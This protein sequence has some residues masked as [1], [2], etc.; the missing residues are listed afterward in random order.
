[1]NSRLGRWSARL[2]RAALA[3][4]RSWVE[5]GAA[6]QAAALV[7]VSTQPASE[8]GAAEAPPAASVAWS[9]ADEGPPED[10][11]RYVTARSQALDGSRVYAPRTA[12][13]R[14]A[15]E[16]LAPPSFRR[17]A[18]HLAAWARARLPLPEMRPAE[19]SEP[20]RAT[21]ARAGGNDR[22]GPGTSQGVAPGAG[23]G[24]MPNATGPRPGRSVAAAELAP[25]PASTGRPGGV[26]AR[27]ASP[28]AEVRPARARPSARPLEPASP[29]PPRSV[30]TSESEPP[31]AEV[32]LRDPRVPPRMPLPRELEPAAPAAPPLAPPARSA[33]PASTL[34]AHAPAR[35]GARPGDVA[36]LE[37][38]P[39]RAREPAP[40]PRAHA[41]A[42]RVEH[43]EL[44]PRLRLRASPELARAEPPRHTGEPPAAPPPRE[45][46]AA[47]RA[48][49]PARGDVRAEL[50][51]SAAAFTASGAASASSPAAVPHGAASSSRAAAP[52]PAGT[53]P[54]HFA[55]P[56]TDRSHLKTDRSR[57][58]N[59]PARTAPAL[60]LAPRAPQ[61]GEAPPPARFAELPRR[62]VAPLAHPAVDAWPELPPSPA[63]PIGAHS[64]ERQNQL[65]REQSEV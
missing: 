57:N 46:R 7:A 59:E 47:R 35:R 12:T 51:P 20:A 2:E 37:G 10:W 28:S 60:G 27:D 63:D 8:E 14:A 32:Q 45:A 4:A 58:G 31:R 43:T 19:P 13:E 48:Q 24:A 30:S 52:L 34:D 11:L 15:I 3:F 33:T 29:A 26:E 53:R 56:E 36:R 16:P 50:L 9:A 22:V 55:P 54:Q 64:P 62:A 1:V 44:A 65:L 39:S 23:H 61:G 6:A 40:L 21:P 41:R 49:V 42:G 5:D 18:R 25:A 17:S 38:L